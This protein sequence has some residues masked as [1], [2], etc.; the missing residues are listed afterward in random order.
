MIIFSNEEAIFIT[1]ASLLSIIQRARSSTA[2]NQ[3]RKSEQLHTNNPS[4]VGPREFAILFLHV[5][6]DIRR[7]HCIIGI[8]HISGTEVYQ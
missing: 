8:W 2:N 5:P 4:S 6:R 3:N 1:K 7:G